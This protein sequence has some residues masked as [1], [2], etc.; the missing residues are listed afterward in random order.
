[1]LRIAAD[2]DEFAVVVVERA[3]DGYAPHD[4]ARHLTTTRDAQHLSRQAQ[5]VRS[6]ADVVD[7]FSSYC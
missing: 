4:W 7:L 6:S 5:Q 3:V 1:L 2:A